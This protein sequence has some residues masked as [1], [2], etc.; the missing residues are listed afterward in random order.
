MRMM[1]IVTGK[2]ESSSGIF[3]ASDCFCSRFILLFLWY[4]SVVGN[5]RILCIE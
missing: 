1:L 3:P 4:H 2:G 5:I